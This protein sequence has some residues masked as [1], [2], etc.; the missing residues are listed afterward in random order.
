MWYV[1]GKDIDFKYEQPN[2]APLLAAPIRR[3]DGWDRG[4]YRIGYPLCY[5]GR[6]WTVDHHMCI[7]FHGCVSL[8]ARRYT[9][10]PH[11]TIVNT[12]VVFLCSNCS[13]LTFQTLDRAHYYY[14]YYY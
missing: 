10:T 5:N 11:H 9:R 6:A 4:R 1:L 7:V 2:D 13:D 3:E 8:R 12:I 14:N